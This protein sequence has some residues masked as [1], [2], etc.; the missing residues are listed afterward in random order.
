MSSKFSRS[1]K[2]VASLALIFFLFSGIGVFAQGAWMP[3]NADMTYPRTLVKLHE[4][5]ALR[6]WITSQPEIYELYEKLYSQAWSA[7]PTVTVSNGQRR[8]AAHTAKNSSFI[9][10]I[11]R[12]PVNGGLDT[13]TTLEADRFRNKAI[14]MLN[15][16]NNDV[17]AYPNFSNY[18]WRSSEI[19]ENLIAYDLLKGAGIPDSLLANGRTLLHD[20]LT[21]FHAQVSF[22]AFNLGL[23]SLHVDNH[24]LRAVGAIGMGAVVLNDAQS[25]DTDG[26]PSTWI[27]TALF[28]IDNVLWSD[29]ASQSEAGVLAGYSEGPHYLRFG[30]KHNLEFFHALANFVP[31]TTISASFDGTTRNIR[32]PFY[33]PSFDNLWE[34]AMRIRMPD[35]RNPRLEDCFAVTYNPDMA[36]TEKPE[37]RP[38]FYASR[39]NWRGPNTLWEELHHS[40]DDLVAD[41]IASMT[42]SSPIA[43]PLLQVL[44]ES[45]NVVFR[46]GWDSTSTYMHL[47]AKNGRARAS[48]NG[49]NQVDVT[50]FEL[51]ARGQELARN[52]GYLKWDRRLEVAGPEHHNMILV[53]GEG[54]ANAVSGNAGGADGFAENDFSLS[55]MDFAEV[56]TNYKNTDIIRK[57][58][59]IRKD[60]FLMADEVWANN[61]HSFQWRLHAQGLI[62]G[63]STSGDFVLDSLNQLAT[64]TKNEVNLAAMVTATGGIDRLGHETNIHELYYDSSETHSTLQVWR[65]NV[66]ETYFMAAL[67]PYELDTPEVSLAGTNSDAIR[68]DRGGYKDVGFVGTAYTSSTGLVVDLFSDAGFSFYSEANNGDF[69]DLFL[70][71]GSILENGSD[72]LFYASSNGDWAL[73]RV[74]PDNYEAYGNQAATVYVYG[75]GFTPASV[76][77]FG[78]VQSWSYDAGL[79]RTEIVLSGPGYYTIHK[80][81]IVGQENQMPENSISAWPNP[82]QGNFKIETNLEAGSAKVFS[83]NGALLYSREFAGTQFEL[84]LGELAAGV[85]FLRIANDAG[86]FVGVEKLVV[87]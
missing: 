85:Y 8:H 30:M 23:T 87:E 7:N 62:N 2:T 25:G 61:N 3:S 28:Q 81:F 86:E 11:N 50:S 48:A 51:H 82:S 16:I 63:D 69:A 12:K 6:T 1:F 14:D 32:H 80:A 5:P 39:L 67:I 13:L 34:W 55:R 72:T 22:D 18:L 36:M 41:F 56:R 37:F 45:G 57:P 26:R 35:G 68:I 73:S 17:E 4:L 43:Y 60:Y 53:D 15:L 59:F 24:T 9:L 84:D 19:C 47:G 74:D 65:E 42:P 71:E 76:L 27:Q 38:V 54:P 10:L 83:S 66:S 75:L 31:D 20:Y 64:W 58:L 52:P 49:H 40:S 33:D 46:S 79:D 70:E 29:N 77:G 78:V 44:P 21:D